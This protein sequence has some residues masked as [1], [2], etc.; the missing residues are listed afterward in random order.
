MIATTEAM[1]QHDPLPPVDAAPMPGEPAS[2]P[3]P[4]VRFPDGILGFPEVEDYLLMSTELE[5]VYWLQARGCSPLSFVLAD[6]FGMVPGFSLDLG[7]A[8]LG[9]LAA[10]NPADLAVLAILTLRQNG[11][12]VTANLQGPVVIDLKRRLG[13]QIVLA[14]SPWGVRHAVAFPPAREVG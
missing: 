6:P 4:A 8:E 14:D 1:P 11:D 12:D 2:S 9:P 7:D 5:G 13:R 3:E 10:S